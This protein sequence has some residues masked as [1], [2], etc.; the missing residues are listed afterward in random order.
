MGPDRPLTVYR[1]RKGRGSIF[2][3]S[4]DDGPLENLSYI[5]PLSNFAS[6]GY[7]DAEHGSPVRPKSLSDDP[8]LTPKARRSSYRT[9]SAGAFLKSELHSGAR[10]PSTKPNS[11]RPLDEISLSRLNI[12]G[13]NIDRDSPTAPE[14]RPSKSKTFFHKS[15]GVRNIK[16][17]TSSIRRVESLYNNSR[18]TLH[19]HISRATRS[20][21]S[22]SPDADSNG[23][24]EAEI[25][26]GCNDGLSILGPRIVV[27]PELSCVGEGVCTL[28]VAV[29]I[30]G[31]GSHK[32][33]NE[34]LHSMQV[35]L[36]AG[37]DCVVS[38]IVGNLYELK[39]VRL[40]ETHLI[41]AKIRLPL[42]ARPTPERIRGCG[43]SEELIADL[44]TELGNCFSSY[45]TV[46]LTYEH[47]GFSNPPYT[48][49]SDCGLS[50]HT[51][52]LQ[53]E[54]TA[55]IRRTRNSTWATCNPP[56]CPN[57]LIGLIETH[58]TSEKARDAV[59]RLGKERIKIPRA[60]RGGAYSFQSGSSEE[61]VKVDNTTSLR[62]ILRQPTLT[63]GPEPLKDEAHSIK[64]PES[65]P[66]RK[67]WTEMRRTSRTRHH[68]KS[69][70]QGT[71]L[72]ME[73]NCSPN[74][75][76]S[77]TSV[78]EERNRIKQVALR[79][80]RSVG[81]D[82]LRS[83]APSVSKA[84]GGGSV[85]GSLGLGRSWGWGGSWW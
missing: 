28:W 20:C 44:E 16:H 5:D 51:T 27:T 1:R 32:S 78:D 8:D 62:T 22:V 48:M 61:M 17:T 46:R 13:R 14:R 47:S 19:H 7:Q 80:K 30:T 41:L 34:C 72:P 54:A 77:A 2:N 35:C 68:R 83:I 73:Q 11:S 84:K 81:A 58:Y 82:T 12:Y 64:I 25:S 21:T 60:R 10:F 33:F 31:V 56:Y 4:L 29:E 49:N 76:S 42:V 85:A 63:D 59:R 26:M 69:I 39:T 53:T 36:V 70:S 37:Q 9:A 52:T 45:L 38:E 65:D 15:L 71:Y 18:G 6:Y 75:V 57:P 66:A 40:H 55:Y 50:F 43:T 67:I 23:S 74:Y 79:N 24:A 3:S